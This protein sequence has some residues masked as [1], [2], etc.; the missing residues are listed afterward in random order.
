MPSTNRWAV[1]DD[2]HMPVGRVAVKTVRMRLDAV[3]VE[4][5]ASLCASSD[6]TGTTM[7]DA[8]RVHRLRVATRRALAAI[9]AFGDVLP[10]RRR[11]W[12]EK[13]LVRLRR[14]AGEARDLDVL[15]TRLSRQETPEARS[16]RRLVAM[17]SKQRDQSRT[18]IRELH[19]VL[20]EED[21]PGRVDRLV[22]NVDRRR[23]QPDFG[24][25]ASR[26]FKPMIAD[27]FAVADGPLRNAAG[28]HALRI[29]GKKLR[30][31]L[32]IFATAMPGKA[33]A[34]CRKSLELMQ[35]SL[36]EFTD[37]AAAADRLARWARSADAGA[38]REF[39]TMLRRDETA[40]AA[41]ARK[42]FSRWWNPARRRSL[43]KRLEQASKRRSA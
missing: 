29:Q 34:R 24:S 31:A 43:R 18:P 39:L 1:R 10:A 32:E 37:H 6:P 35:Q 7:T 12:F 36:G 13:R 40:K 17:L 11:A 26:H 16:R 22:E 42:A 25:Y 41:A 23:R 19:E 20:T 14:A 30:Y 2:D 8:E 21:W 4:L 5:R 27:F 3:W 33:V 9:D 38:S 28:M 15:S